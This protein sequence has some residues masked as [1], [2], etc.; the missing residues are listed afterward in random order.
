VQKA[1]AGILLALLS[2]LST[3]L[4]ADDDYARNA[5]QTMGRAAGGGPIEAIW[6]N[7]AL[8]GTQ[9]IPRTGLALLPF[10]NYGMSYWSDALQVPLFIDYIHLAVLEGNESFNHRIRAG[11][12]VGKM[13]DSAAVQHIRSN[14]P[15]GARLYSDLTIGILSFSM[16][17]MA[18]AV[19]TEAHGE[20]SLPSP[21]LV[22]LV[23]DSARFNLD[24]LD[25]SSFGQHTIW[26]SNA[27][28]AVGTPLPSTKVNAF[29]R[30]PKTAIGVRA[31]YI[32]GHSYLKTRADSAYGNH[33]VWRAR[34]QSAGAGLSPGGFRTPINGHGYNLDFGAVLY[35]ERAGLSI[36]VENIGSIFW[37]RDIAE[38]SYSLNESNLRYND[39]F[40]P[41]GRDTLK[42][43]S[44]ATQQPTTLSI[45]YSYEWQP[46]VN[47]AKVVRLLAHSLYGAATFRY[48]LRDYPGIAAGPAGSVGVASGMLKGHLPVSLGWGFGGA[49]KIGSAIGLGADFGN[50]RLDIYYKAVG[51]PVWNPT[52]GFELGLSF[53]GAWKFDRDWDNDRIVD[54]LDKCRDIPED[55]D[56]FQDSDGCP[57]PDNDSDGIADNLDS[58]PD[59]AEDLDSVADNDGC[60]D[61]D[62][63]LDGV[64]DV[65]D[66]CPK[67]AEDPDGFDDADG[68]PD[69]DNDNDSLPDLSD[70]CPNQAEDFDGVSDSDGCPDFD[71]D[72]DGVADT[73]D[74][75]PDAAED[76]D[77]FND[78]DGCPDLDNDGDGIADSV[79]KCPDSAEVMNRYLDDDGCPDA[80][81][82]APETKKS[83]AI[84]Y[85]PLDSV[86]YFEPGMAEVNPAQKASLLAICALLTQNSKTHFA[87]QGHSDSIGEP[88]FNLALSVAR[89]N[90]VRDFLISQGIDGARLVAIGYGKDLPL[91]ANTTATGRAV[92]RRVDFAYIDTR[93]DFARLIKKQA[94]QQKLLKTWRGR[95]KG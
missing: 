13:R 38:G 20:L 55:R 81:P 73:V 71:N 10:S 27:R 8:L 66:S 75:C 88:G 86:F 30:L 56:G 95:G 39:Y 54:K 85:L 50:P 65:R 25:F 36:Q 3:V 70:G 45:G 67:Q 82:S 46:P 80:L 40:P 4:A 37:I 7:P 76:R 32:M 42:H 34:Y 60:P 43:K 51:S 58:C 69:F 31:T 61:F 5:G 48:V 29:L 2:L 74:K 21:A 57:D 17:R 94:G 9:R 90:N 91:A 78:A 22:A 83:P 23:N 93:D 64:P 72:S 1:I 89:A 53:C 18:F 87:I 11:M 28:V 14:F 62:N 15:H 47:A 49:E 77:G 26:A 12:G 33:G 6:A 44:F 84:Q 24:A 68:C 59:N 63:D 79:D 19:N 52:R 16:R 35:G 92:N 41:S